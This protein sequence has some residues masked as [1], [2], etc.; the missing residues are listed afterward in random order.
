MVASASLPVRTRG[1]WS[2]AAAAGASSA[3]AETKLGVAVK[4]RRV[5]SAAVGATLGAGRALLGSL[6]IT[7]RAPPPRSDNHPRAGRNLRGSLVGQSSPMEWNWDCGGGGT[8][9]YR[10]P[11]T[12][13]PEGATTATREVERGL[14]GSQVDTAM[15]VQSNDE[16]GGETTG[17]EVKQTAVNDKPRDT[18]VAPA[19]GRQSLRPCPLAGILD[20]SEPPLRGHRRS[21]YNEGDGR[22]YRL[23]QKSDTSTVAGFEE[24]PREEERFKCVVDFKGDVQH[25][26]DCALR[27]VTH[28]TLP[29]SKRNSR[30]LE[31][32]SGQ[33][34][35]TLPLQAPLS[36]AIPIRTWHREYTSE[37]DPA[38]VGAT[39]E[40][41]TGRIECCLYDGK[42]TLNVNRGNVRQ[43]NI[44]RSSSIDWVD[45]VFVKMQRM[46]TNCELQQ[47]YSNPHVSI[48]GL[49]LLT[50]PN[51]AFRTNH[52]MKRYN[53]SISIAF[54]LIQAG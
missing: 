27:N 41:V 37:W 11:A 17:A 15:A 23:P 48:L 52:T 34:P 25:G 26:E 8:E 24:R 38:G 7:Q 28:K 46:S 30:T 35:P 53:T 10:A 32:D 51:V 50:R 39:G 3:T 47:T 16:G 12:I 2:A 5:K 13:P 20:M 6:T 29:P 31:W 4:E 49:P 22:V 19:T 21:Y 40:R 14:S 45:F 54:G 42:H 33:E 43:W 18:G 9:V 36:A 1:I 44:P